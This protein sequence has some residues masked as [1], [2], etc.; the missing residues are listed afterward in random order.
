MLAVLKFIK[1]GRKL[2]L[3]KPSF[4]TSQLRKENLKAKSFSHRKKPE[5]INQ[6]LDRAS[7]LI[8]TFKRVQ[9]NI[10]EKSF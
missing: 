6:P 5:Y 3:S 2:H 10:L 9:M 7:F 8:E 1:C 4:I